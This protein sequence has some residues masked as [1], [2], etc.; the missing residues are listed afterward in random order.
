MRFSAVFGALALALTSQ[1]QYPGAK[2]AP[3]Q[4]KKGFDFIKVQD[5]Q[6][7]LGFLGGPNCV[8][9][10]PR[11]PGF[12]IAA[13]YCTAWAQKNGL[14]PAGDNG[15]YFQ[16][17]FFDKVTTLPNSVSLRS[18]DGKF[19][20][21]YGQDFDVSLYRETHSKSKFAFIRLT[22][23]GMP[24]IDANLVKDRIVI[25]SSDARS[26]NRQGY[27]QL[28]NEL[29]QAA[30]V[31]LA[32]NS[33]QPFE[34]RSSTIIRGSDSD[35]EGPGAFRM[36]QAAAAALAKY[37]GASKF[38]AEAITEPS[39]ELPEGEFTLSGD[40][41]RE[42]DHATMNVLMKVEGVDPVLKDETVII[43]AH[44]DHLG[45]S[46]RGTFYGADDNG[47][48]STAA[49]LIGSAIAQNPIKPKRSV[50]IALWSHEESGLLG[51]QYY[52]D[53]PVVPMEDTVAYLNMDMVG[54]N[55]NY[56]PWG[57]LAENNVDGV[58][59]GSA[60][61][62]SPDLYNLMHEANK[63]VNLNLRDDKEDRTMRSDT[64]SFAAHDVPILKAFT[65]EHE[66]YHKTTDTL[67]KINWVKLI[68]ISKW[69]YLG[70]QTLANQSSRPAF[71]RG[72]SYLAGRITYLPKVALSPDAILEV[73]LL[74]LSTT[75]QKLQTLDST[76][77]KK[78][79]Q[80]PIMWTLIYFPD[81]L[82][83]TESYAI[84]ATISEKGKLVFTTKE[85]V[86][87]LKAGQPRSGI[88]LQLEPAK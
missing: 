63:F 82:R 83:D 58:F 70:A 59:C 18:A 23:D 10:N 41:K 53:H 64:G 85:P 56:K 86:P 11:Q 67:E 50:I 55:C 76:I 21:T 9:R 54:R 33:A 14:L 13:G 20:L 62:W 25:F 80:I 29:S 6:E 81:R 36:N 22:K 19:Q 84:Q 88:E 49:L 60:K 69:L 35:K 34:P 28:Q 61:L 43:G 46:T 77:I 17:F 48:G 24:T 87:V 5:A 3:A 57:E 12:A 37:L 38:G 2:P 31:V 52:A 44:L 75:G 7:I 40:A 4:W 42:L 45:V 32:T 16:P 66:D 1:A 39:V 73:S 27:Q 79:G 74:K 65:G 71:V 26:I 78:G 47:S 51:S 72:A 30:Q 15:S 8:G 68:N